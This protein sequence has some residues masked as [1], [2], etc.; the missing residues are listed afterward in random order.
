[1]SA[2]P[3][4][5]SVGFMMSSLSSL[6]FLRALCWIGVRF[7]NLERLIFDDSSCWDSRSDFSKFVMLSSRGRGAGGGF[8]LLLHL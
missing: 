1:M 4:F 7:D 2:G 6:S 5:L 3:R 8:Q